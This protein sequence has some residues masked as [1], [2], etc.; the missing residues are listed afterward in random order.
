MSS[1]EW[2]EKYTMLRM[3]TFSTPTFMGVGEPY[4]D[5]MQCESARPRNQAPARCRARTTSCIVEEAQCAPRMRAHTCDRTAHAHPP[6]QLTTAHWGA[7]S[8]R[9]SRARG[10]RATTGTESTADGRACRCCLRARSS[11]T[12][13]HTSGNGDWGR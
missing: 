1:G 9:T 4:I 5:K 3:G 6:S 11:S 10:R 8:R 2:A 12:R 7:S 13:T